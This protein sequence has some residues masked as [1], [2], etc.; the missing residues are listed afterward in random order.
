LALA[1]TFKTPVLQKTSPAQLVAS[2][3][4]QVLGDSIRQYTYVDFCAGA[5][6]P[7]PVIA[8]ELNKQL[9]PPAGTEPVNGEAAREPVKFVLTDLHPHI[10]DWVEASKKSPNLSFV[11]KSV[12]ATNAP[13]D[14]IESDGKKVF[15]LFNLAFHHFDDKLG[16]DILRNTLETADG[17]G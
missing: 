3:L 16:K 12:D 1:W 2:T 4:R 8:K 6:G 11:S 14:L 13:S 7:T 10:K 5:G 9:Q 15:R 17:F